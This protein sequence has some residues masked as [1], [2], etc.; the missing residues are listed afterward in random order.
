MFKNK[1]EGLAF[2]ALCM[3]FFM[4]ILDVTIVNVALPTITSYFET[5][6]SKLQWVVAG[7]TLAFACCLLLVGSLT[8]YFG[9]KKIFLLGLIFFSITSLSCALADSIWILIFC[10]ILQGAAAAFLLPSSLALINSIFEEQHQ[11]AK[12]IGM[13]AALGGVACATG[14]FLGGILTATF[15]WRA[16]FLVNL[17]ISFI[18][19]VLAFTCIAIS[20]S[21]K[22]IIKMDVPGQIIAFSAVFILA[23]ALIEIGNTGFTKSIFIYFIISFLLSALFIYLENRVEYPMMP[24]SLFKNRMISMGLIVSGILNLCFY[25][26]LFTL[27]FY[28]ANIR[29]YS[30]FVVGLALLPLPALAVFGSYL[31]GKCTGGFGPARVIFIGFVI[32][33]IGFLTLLELNNS[34][35]PYVLIMLPFL[36]IGF[37]VSFATPAM[38]F[39]V[40]HSASKEYEGTVSAILNIFNQI[41]NLMGVAIFGTIAITATSFIHGLH[42]IFLIIGITFLVTAASSL[43]IMKKVDA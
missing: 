7:Y 39:A 8:D 34:T 24:L 18:S 5:T 27:P 22:N 35:P 13:W 6:L 4:I 38:T 30:T 20:I 43:V 26:A 12:A 16:V 21:K 42:I 37:G 40:I 10:R 3:G 29:H 28:F 23:F 14:P 25:G 33:A 17:I 11:K 2:I 19:Y 36:T 41:G 9:A 15:S 32:A 1:R 31:G